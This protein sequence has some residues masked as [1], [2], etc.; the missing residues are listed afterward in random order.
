MGFASAYIEERILFPQRI[1]E[2]PDR[3]TGII[4]VVPAYNEPGLT[5]M[6]DS[7]AGCYIP[8]CKAEVMIVINAPDDATQESLENNRKSLI[9]LESWKKMNSDCFFRLYFFEADHFAVD[10]WGV[11]LARKTGMDEAVRRF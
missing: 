10:R 9:D 4:V 5:Y 2:A 7:L 6:L 11:G 8:E 1:V 3:E